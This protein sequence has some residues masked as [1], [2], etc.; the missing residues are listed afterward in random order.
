[1]HA[2]QNRA[3]T[4]SVYCRQMVCMYVWIYRWWWWWWWLKTMIIFH[5]HTQTHTFKFWFIDC[6]AWIHASHLNC[7]WKLGKYKTEPGQMASSSQTESGWMV[8][9]AKS[10]EQSKQTLHEHTSSKENLLTISRVANAIKTCG[11][12]IAFVQILFTQFSSFTH[13]RVCVCVQCT[14]LLDVHGGWCKQE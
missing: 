11:Y 8:K 6:I 3:F 1:M 5:T 13:I 7:K 4:C 9:E 2:T 14:R 10:V 12:L